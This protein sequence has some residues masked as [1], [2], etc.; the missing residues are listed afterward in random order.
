MPRILRIINRLNIGGPTYNAVFL[1]KYL[2]PEYETCLLSGQIFAGEAS[3]SFVAAENGV[4]PR[5]IRSLERTPNP[6]NDFLAYREIRQIIKEFKPDIVHTHA[7]KPGLVG[8]L[9]AYHEKVP[10]IIHTY[11]GHYFHSYFH[12]I[13][14]KFFLFIE[15][16]LATKST[17]IIA[18]SESQKKELAD[19]YHV[20]DS[21]KIHVVHNGFD[22]SKFT[23]N[24]EFKR[25]SFRQ[26][27]SIS[28]NEIAIGIIGRIVPIKNHPLFLSAC[29]TLKQLCPPNIKLRFFIIGDGTDKDAVEAQAKHLGFTL[30][31]QQQPA[32]LTFTSWIRDIDIATAGLDIIVLSSLNEGT[33]VSLI[34]AQAAA[35]PIV[36][37]RV[38][39]VADIVIPNQTAF[40]TPSRDANAM[41]NALLQLIKNPD[42][43]IQMGN[44]G[45]KYVMER[46][47][48]QTLVQNMRS[49]YEQLFKKAGS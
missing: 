1:T 11:H 14:T 35:K 15:R 7:T 46:F 34:E 3:S 25:K 9:A 39:G 22:L 2:A 29:A 40:V 43:R 48:Y 28:N 38:G 24:Q 5:F 6:F 49:C 44:E 18:I 47:S 8:R 17:G 30:G 41:A 45:R 33:P 4:E 23:D 27:W 36:T 37:T 10:V 26:Q 16:W 20:A 42:Q 32:E 12:P 21:D 31:S 13:I 19:V